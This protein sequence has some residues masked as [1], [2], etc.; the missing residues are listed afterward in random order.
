MHNFG[1]SITVIED[2]LSYVETNIGKITT[3]VNDIIDTQENQMQDN[4][5]LKDK[6][7]DTEDRYHQNNIKIC[8]IPELIQP[9]DLSSYV[10]GLIKSLLPVLK[11]IELVI[12]R[13]HRLPKPSV[14]PATVLREVI[15]RIHFYYVKEHFMQKMKAL[16][17]L[18]DPYG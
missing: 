16:G 11:N 5:R 4:K 10:R 8:R 3:T 9:H 7:G 15:L 12:N 17:A 14:L 18:L 1:H 13:I 2:R 6:L